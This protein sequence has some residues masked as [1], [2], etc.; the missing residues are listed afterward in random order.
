MQKNEILKGGDHMD[1]KVLFVLVAAAAVGVG[2]VIKKR[3]S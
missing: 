3:K 2:A 1:P